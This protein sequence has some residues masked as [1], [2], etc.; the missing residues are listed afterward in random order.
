MMNN[1]LK[2]TLILAASLMLSSCLDKEPGDYIPIDKGMQSVTDAEQIVNGIYN[3]FKGGSLY[4]GRLVLC[5]D[6]QA[7]LVHAVQ[8]NSNTYVNL[9]Q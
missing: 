7:D 1:I 6:I 2:T 8:G 4:S 9:W 3:T 5:P